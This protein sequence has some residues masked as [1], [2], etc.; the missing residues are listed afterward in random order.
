MTTIITANGPVTNKNLH[1]A[2]TSTTLRTSRER[3]RNL[4]NESSQ[5]R[6]VSASITQWLASL[7]MNRMETYSTNS[8][9][10]LLVATSLFLDKVEPLMVLR[11]SIEAPIPHKLRLHTAAAID[12]Y[13]CGPINPAAM[14]SF[15]PPTS[16]PSQ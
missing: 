1:I 2:S 3:S 7:K 15:L 5:P 13:G 16:V 8:P 10:V 11:T 4:P 6:L 14:T 12:A 9:M